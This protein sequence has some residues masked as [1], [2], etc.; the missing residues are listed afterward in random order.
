MSVNLSLRGSVHIGGVPR[1]THG[2]DA[3]MTTTSQLNALAAVALTG[4]FFSHTAWPTRWGVER[5]GLV[6]RNDLDIDAVMAGTFVEFSLT[7][8]GQAALERSPTWRAAQYLIAQGYELEPQRSFKPGF[9][10][11]RKV[12]TTGRRSLDAAWISGGRD[13]WIYEPVAEPEYDGHSTAR[14][15]FPVRRRRAA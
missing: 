2:V 12:G 11:F 3:I 1:H 13:A 14:Q 6:H 9:I 10:R 4:K 8:A 7:E 15:A 5:E